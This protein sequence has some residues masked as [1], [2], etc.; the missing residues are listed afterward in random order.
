MA[1][2]FCRVFVGNDYFAGFR[3]GVHESDFFK[4]RE[5]FVVGSVEGN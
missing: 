2:C 3:T 4:G 5:C 1:N